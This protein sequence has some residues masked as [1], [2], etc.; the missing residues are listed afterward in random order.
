MLTKEELLTLFKRLSIGTQY[1]CDQGP[2]QGKMKVFLAHPY[3]TPDEIASLQKSIAEMEETAELAKGEPEF[4][5][6]ANA[7]I[8]ELIRRSKDDGQ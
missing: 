4:I 5:K 8:I 1:Y 2:N 7:K 3:M 6:S